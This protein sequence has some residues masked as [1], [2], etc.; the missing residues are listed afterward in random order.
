[1]E[2]N[3]NKSVE[4][5]ELTGDKILA[6]HESDNIK[7]LDNRL[8]RWWL[9]LFIITVV[10]GVI[11]FFLF[12]VIKV[13]PHQQEEYSKEMASVAMNTTTTPSEDANLLPLTDKANLDAGKAIWTQRCVVCHLPLGQGLV[14]PNLTDTFAIHGC[15]YKDIVT[16]I[17]NGVPEKGMITWKTQLTRDQ[18]LQVASFTLTLKGTNP[19]NP[20][21]PQGEPCK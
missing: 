6:G 11:Y 9:W 12:D 5:D 4:K 2:I 20:K 17:T 16:L 19:P 3:E 7:E 14:G 10:W 18:I 1:M 21:P 8:P 15:S 13:M